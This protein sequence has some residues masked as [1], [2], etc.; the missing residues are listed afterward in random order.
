MD[1]LDTA[2]SALASNQ[3]L[4]GGVGTLAF[5]SLMYVLRTVPQ[6]ILDVVE[7]TVWTTVSVENMSNEYRDVD[8][9]IERLRLNFF[10]RSLEI[11]D[12][13]LKTGFGGGWGTYDGILFKYSKTRSEQRPH[14]Q[15]NV[16][17]LRP[18]RS[19]RGNTSVGT[20]LRYVQVLAAHFPDRRAQL[21]LNLRSSAA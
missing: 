10:S 21:R 13:Y 18:T 4:V 12:G 7:K 1:L 19:V 15:E 17:K 11:K 14:T 16:T 20:R 2:Y 9:F 8:A 5:G 3:L 6:K